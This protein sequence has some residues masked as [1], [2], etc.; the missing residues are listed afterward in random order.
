MVAAGQ[1]LCCVSPPE[2]VCDLSLKFR[3][4][5]CN[6]PQ[7]EEI[8]ANSTNDFPSPPGVLGFDNVV[9]PYGVVGSSS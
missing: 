7:A 4:Q 3:R 6:H 1:C 5:Q 8:G 2:E 9:T